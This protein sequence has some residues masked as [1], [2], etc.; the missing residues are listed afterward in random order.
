MNKT[1]PNKPDERAIISAR[2][3]L[4][5]IKCDDAM[6]REVVDYCELRRRQLARE[7]AK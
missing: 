6:L 2:L 3:R 7:R 5:L 4:D 1:I